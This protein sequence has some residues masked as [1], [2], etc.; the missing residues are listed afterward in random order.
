VVFDWDVLADRIHVS[1]EA[2]LQLGMKRGALEGPASGWF[3]VLHP[4]DRDRYSACLD[5]VLEQRRGRINLDFRLRAADGHY[6]WFLLKA[7]PVVGAD[8]DVIR[9]IGTLSD[10]TEGK[11]AEERLL[12]DA[13]HDNLTG[14]PN[15]ELF[16]DRLE[17]ALK[18]AA[19]ENTI[20]PSVLAIDLDRFR[21]VNDAAGMAAGDSILLT[22]ARRL[23]RVLKPQ[24]TLAR[25]SSDQFAII[26]VSEMEAAPITALSETIRRT[27]STPV[28]F[29][30]REIALTVSVG[31]ALFDPQQHP[32]SDDMLKDAEMALAAAKRLGGNRIEVFRPSLRTRRS[33]RLSI[34]ADLRHALERDE[35]KVF[36]QPIVRLEDRTIAGFE[37]LLR[38]HHP[39]LGR[40][41]PADFIPLA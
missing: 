12:H 18:T 31:I 34:E 20:R 3:E 27:L 14:L 2:E 7:R 11:M 22:A 41:A 8:G 39:R 1:H 35:I 28:T 23:G 33:D 9:V 30:D 6:L 38:W 5:T 29:N 32:K 36:F 37:A 40:L 24:D 21:Q 19:V 26:I 10:V 4:F 15:R 13:V 16:F 25:V 17:A